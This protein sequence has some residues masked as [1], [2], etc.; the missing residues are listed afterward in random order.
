M[1]PQL[2]PPIRIG[3]GSK[4]RHSLE[5]HLQ[6]TLSKRSAIEIDQPMAGQVALLRL[7]DEPLGILEQ[8]PLP[9][10]R[11]GVARLASSVSAAD[12]T[13]MS[14][15]VW[16]RSTASLPSATTPGWA[17]SRCIEV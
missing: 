7:E 1:N 17:L 13:T 15:G 10:D 11:L 12:R 3:P 4:R 16:P 9:T 5:L 2:K 8:D 14:P 6:L